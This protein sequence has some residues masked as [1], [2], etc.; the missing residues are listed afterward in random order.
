MLCCESTF[1]DTQF[2]KDIHNFELVENIIWTE[3]INNF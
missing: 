1:F 2:Y 3:K